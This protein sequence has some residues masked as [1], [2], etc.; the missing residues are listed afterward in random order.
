MTTADQTRVP[1]PTGAP[2]HDPSEPPQPYGRLGR[3]GRWASAHLRLVAVLWLAL[4]AGLGAFA[5]QVTSSLAGAGW[6]AD[7]S[8]SVKV[9]ELADAHFGGNASSALQVVVAADRPVTDPAVASVIERAG[10]LLAADPRIERVVPPEP[11]V[12]VGPDGRTAILLA[13]AGAD[14]DDMV[15]AAD[16]LKGPLAALSGG[17]VQVSAT[18]ASVLWSDFNAANHDAMMKS[19]MLSWPVTLAILVLA[20]GSLVAAGLPLLLTL[21]GLAASAGALVLLNHLTPTSVWAMNFAMMF[22]LA[23]GIDYA[24]FLVVRFRSALARHGDARR[25]V[26]ETMDTAGKAVALSGVTVLVSLSAVLLVPAPAF[27]SM[28]LGIMLAVTFVL[29][30]TLTL[31]PAVLGRLGRRVNAGAL[32]RSRRAAGQSEG[33]ARFTAWGERLWAH[34]LRYGVPALLVLLALA[35]PVIGLRTAMPSITVVP[36]DSSA[37]TGYTAVQRAFGPGAPGALQI[38]TPAGQADAAAAVLRD[39]ASIA[40][41]MP[42]QQAADGSGLTMLQAVPAVDPSDPALAATVEQLRERLPEQALVGG[43]AVE[44]LDLQSMLDGKTPLVVGV[45]LAMGFVLLLLALQAPLLALLGTVTYLLATAA[46][47]G[48]ARLV[49]QDGHGA[50]LLGF[51][52]QGFLDGWAPV[53]FFAMIFAIAM[54]Y[55]VFLLS[56]AKEHHERTGDPRR[57][58]VGALAHS[59]RVVFAAA[60]VMVAVFLTFALSGPLPPKEMGIVLGLAVLLDAALVR[61]V[62]LPVLLRLT[63]RAAWWSPAWLRRVLP[64]IRFSH[65]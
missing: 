42:A 38:V 36:E 60:A 13:G 54:D 26:G 57:A 50:G 22:A 20:F 4:V 33:S 40:A 31:L 23:L 61:L 24:L 28:A 58:V 55:T 59:G 12:T 5:P 62:L 39:S 65:G 44:N 1:P 52:P 51:E 53:F 64:D 46:A 49:F 35:A 63:G 45:V 8:E 37:R 11:G 47:F 32:P 16:D 21:A 7:G 43:A 2:G 3:L 6:Q 41:V 29:A 9:R 15:R 25:A 48:A 27:R 19:E 18:G 56:S 17:G 34:P 10:A 30:A 14:T